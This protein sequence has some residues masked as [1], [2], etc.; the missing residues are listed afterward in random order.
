MKRRE[1]LILVFF[2]AASLG[3]C[4]RSNTLPPEE[5]STPSTAE[6][7]P[8]EP[9]DPATVGE[10]S[11]Q[12]LFEGQA[13]AQVQ[14]AMNAAACAE[15]NNK[16]PVFREDL[17]V[18]DNKTLRDVFVYV[19]E[20][21]GYRRFAAPAEPV[22]LDQKGC[23]FRPHV[24]GLMA[25]QKLEIKNSDN[26]SHNIHPFPRV[27]REW[28]ESMSPGSADLFERF[29]LPEVMIP[30]RCNV[31]QWMRAYI[32]V[33]SS[34]FFAVTDDQGAFTLKGL[35]PGNYTIEAWQEKLGVQDQKVTLGPKEVKT[36]QFSFK[37]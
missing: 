36:V 11:G 35:P 25:G 30:V 21:L 3:G 7:P 37:G 2:V 24:L 33:V 27:N 31:H 23:W 1:W 16:E 9:I 4:S 12:A 14:V 26:V 22:M 6:V 19:K 20:G 29:A 15:A 18:N 32:G 17:V 34:P 8:P 10:I 5:T 28:N 13:P